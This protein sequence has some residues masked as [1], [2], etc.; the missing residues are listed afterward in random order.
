MDA[1]AGGSGSVVRA[2]APDRPRAWRSPGAWLIL[3]VVLGLG[4]AIDL[5]TKAWSFRNVAS[6]PVALDREQLLSDPAH[7]P[8]GFHRSMAILPGGMLE[9]KLVLNPGAV[10]GIGSSHR[11]FFI[12]FTV[13]AIAAG[14][15]VF[16]RYT[17]AGNH[18]AHIAIGLVLA[19]GLGNLYDRIVFGR[20]RD[21]IQV[22]AGRRLP[23]G[24]T[25]P[26]TNNPEMFPWV[27]NIADVLL[28]VGMIA[29]MMHV[30]RVEKGRKGE[31]RKGLRD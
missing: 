5:Q 8:I 14:I 30:N 27:F 2:G 13:V 29:L 1:D 21:F 31:G 19:G 26:G 24:W 25:W 16:G 6:A 15:L 23:F 18:L 22:L 12:V 3:L 17:E 20:V 28:L 9:L 4:F 11:W 10:F 7:D